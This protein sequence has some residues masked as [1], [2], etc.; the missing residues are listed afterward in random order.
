[1]SNVLTF[2]ETMG[3]VRTARPGPIAVQRDMVMSMGGAE[4]NVAIALTRLGIPTTWAGR[5]GLDAVGQLIARELRAEQVTAV[6]DWDS[7]HPTG[8]MLKQARFEGRQE[9]LYYRRHSP[10][11]RMNPSH[12]DVTTGDY[13]VVHTTGIT[14]SLSRSTY[15][16]VVQTFRTA[17]E[18]GIVTSFDVNYRSRLWTREAASAV[19]RRIVPLCDILFA[20]V[21]E[22]ALIADSPSVEG[23]I[24]EVHASGPAEVLIKDG[25]NGSVGGAGGEIH[26]EPAINVN[27]VDTVGAGDGYVAGYLAARLD[28]S[29]LDV[30]MRLASFVG[31]L[32][33]LSPGDWEG[34]PSREDIVGL[35]SSEPVLR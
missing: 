8:L 7:G 16:T 30:R 19:L 12:V 1:M 6:I 20:G 3:L 9:V 11:T 13:R 14:A 25:A 35:D 10:A 17:R 21:D 32:A 15:D 5:L 23:R 4:S 29:P 24:R 28:G 33:C 2:G 31:G 34:Y 27:P 18:L 22:L 26:R